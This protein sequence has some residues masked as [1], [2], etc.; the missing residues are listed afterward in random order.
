MC[1]CHVETVEAIKLTYL[2]NHTT[3]PSMC[4][5]IELRQKLGNGCKWT[6]FDGLSIRDRVVV[7]VGW[8]CEERTKETQKHAFGLGG[9]CHVHEGSCS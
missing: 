8:G 5:S 9:T 3:G 2:L 6:K 4:L 7:G 1:V